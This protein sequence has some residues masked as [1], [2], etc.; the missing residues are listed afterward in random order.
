MSEREVDVVVVGLGPGGEALATRLAQGGL[1]VVGVDRRLVGGECPYYGCIPS[2]MMLHAAGLVATARRVDGHAGHATVAPDWSPV[3]ARIRDEATTDW[4][5]QVAVDRLEKAGVTFVRGDARLSGPRRVEVDGTTYVARAGV[6]L[7][8]GTQPSAP[9]IDGLAG[10]PYWTNREAVQAETAPASLVVIGGGAIGAEMAQAFARFGTEVTVLEA[11]PR[12][13]GPE[14]PEASAALAEVFEAEG[15]TVLTGVSVDRVS[16]SDDR[17]TVEVGERTVHA[18]R[19]LVA[20]GR[21][22]NLSGLGLETVGLHDDARSVDVD[23]RMRAGDG[24]WAIGDITGKGAFTHMSMYQSAIAARD[25]LGEDGP[26]AAY[27]AVPHVTFTDPEVGAVGMTEQQAREAGLNVQIGHSDLGASTRGWIA[28]AQ[29]LVKLIADA[30]RGVLVGATVVGPSGGEVLSMLVT[31]V[32]AR[33]P[34]E[35]L[36]SMIY[37]YPTFH[38]AV[39]VAVEDLQG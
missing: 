28:G 10:T 33:V 2:K 24:L 13:L 1:E 37:A 7:N 4:N 32:H 23:D 3:H 19:L 5:D 8:T 11:G 22:P 14:E 39:E 9:P 36:R 16:H 20:A 31:A 34:V 21:R 26:A 17:F 15:I 35:T 38:R 29:G 18:E 27:H 12:I 6:V 25:I 30:D